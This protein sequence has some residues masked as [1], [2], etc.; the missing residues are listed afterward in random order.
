MENMRGERVVSRKGQ[1]GEKLHQG[2]CSED[3][4][5]VVKVIPPRR[6]KKFL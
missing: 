1:M 4:A 2:G 3:G 6:K 5:Q